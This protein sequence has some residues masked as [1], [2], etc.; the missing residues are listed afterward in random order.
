MKKKMSAILISTVL[1]I[2]AAM[3]GVTEVMASGP[4]LEC[5]DGIY[6]VIP[7]GEPF[8]RQY[9][10]L[11]DSIECENGWVWEYEISA[12]NSKAMSA[13]TKTHVYIPSTPPN[14]ITVP[15]NPD[16]DNP[17]IQRGDGAQST[18]KM[19]G[20][21]IFNG[22]TI[23]TTPLS[24]VSSGKLISFC[25]DV[26]TF[27]TISIGFE[28]SRTLTG[29]E[30]TETDD[31]GPLGGIIGPGFGQ[32]QYA[33]FETDKRIQLGSDPDA[34]VCAKKHPMTGCIK[35]FY[36]CSDTDQV[37]PKE[38]RSQTDHPFLDGGEIVDMGNLE[39]PICREAIFARKGSPIQYWGYA[40]GKYFCIGVYGGD[41]I[42]QSPCP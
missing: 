13:I 25:T 32:S 2:M 3:V 33:V 8:P 38:L 15:P 21:G 30:A 10:A 40:N 36:E 22:V 28:T 6:S 14:V 39:D 7:Y 20:N 31:Q 19:Y 29:C 1:V 27:G 5:T 23:T 11:I 26:N 12:E 4:P 17:L 18:G 9:D 37:D 35:Y 41:P 42:W 24:G 34:T 16:I